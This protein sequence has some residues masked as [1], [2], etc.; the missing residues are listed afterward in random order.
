VRHVDVSNY[1]AVKRVKPQF[2]PALSIPF[3]A[4]LASMGVTPF[5]ESETP[6]AMSGTLSA[7]SVRLAEARITSDEGLRSLAS[8]SAPDVSAGVGEGWGEGDSHI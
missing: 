2:A 6:P 4:V 7:G 5:V 3:K 1:W 8:R